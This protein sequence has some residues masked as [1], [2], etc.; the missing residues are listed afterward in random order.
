M[1]PS[2]LKKKMYPLAYAEN[3]AK[4]GVSRDKARY[5]NTKYDQW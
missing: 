4:K 1:T 5:D 3:L 2:K